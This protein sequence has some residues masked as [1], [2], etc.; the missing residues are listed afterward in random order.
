M[1][2]NRRGRR[3]GGRGGGGSRNRGRR[4]TFFGAFKNLEIK[5]YFTLCYIDDIAIRILKYRTEFPSC[6]WQKIYSMINGLQ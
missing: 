1:R 5:I 6:N 3:G 4:G 2:W